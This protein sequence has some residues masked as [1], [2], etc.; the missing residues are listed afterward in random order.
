MES[1]DNIL[2]HLD[3]ALILLERAAAIGSGLE[4]GIRQDIKN[5]LEMIEDD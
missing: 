4:D 2:N 1:Y 3:I 5:L